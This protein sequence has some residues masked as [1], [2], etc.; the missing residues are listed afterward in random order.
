MPINQRHNKQ[1]HLT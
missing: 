1:N